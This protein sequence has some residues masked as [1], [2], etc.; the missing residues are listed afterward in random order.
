MKFSETKLAMMMCNKA[1]RVP[2]EGIKLEKE[3]MEEEIKKWS[4]GKAK[5]LEE[6]ITV[7][8]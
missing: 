8:K 5:A 7:T 6:L 3:N 1:K 4:T 2:E